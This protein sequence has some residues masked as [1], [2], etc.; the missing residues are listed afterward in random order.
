MFWA[1]LR[2]LKRGALG[3]SPRSKRCQHRFNQREGP[4]K[5]R[6]KMVQTID[7]LLVILIERKIQT[8]EISR[9]DVSFV[10]VSIKPFPHEYT[11]CT[12]LK[13]RFCI[14]VS[15]YQ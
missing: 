1:A 9:G 7:L 11:R 2:L 3:F 13:I 15:V 14:A 6:F 8:R 12:D 5:W 10:R 4:L